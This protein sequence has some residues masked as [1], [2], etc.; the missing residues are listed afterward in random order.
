MTVFD[1]HAAFWLKKAGLPKTLAQHLTD[2]DGN[3]RICDLGCGGGR[4][5]ASLP[6]HVFG[7][8]YSAQLVREA[9]KA[10]PD[11]HFVAGNCQNRETWAGITDLDLIVSNCAIRKDY[12]PHLN[13]LGQCCY[14]S[15]KTDGTLLFR[16]QAS[17]D[18][19]DILPTATRERLFY[20][21]KELV[22]GLSMFRWEVKRE[23]YRQGFSSPEYVLEFLK[24]TQIPPPKQ[25]ATLRIRRDY[26]VLKGTRSY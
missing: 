5:A 11:V 26:L 22:C 7:I 21:E 23:S 8:D 18:F 25:V 2:L 16:V 10:H 17:S 6:G 4:V 9:Q 19:A 3:S 15:L 20:S 1:E 13:K 24:K 14:E 12:T